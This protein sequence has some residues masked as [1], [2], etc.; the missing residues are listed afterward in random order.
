[1]RALSTFQTILFTT[2]RREILFINNLVQFFLDFFTER[3]L[4][5]AKVKALAIIAGAVLAISVTML[6]SLAVFSRARTPM[7]G[8]LG[9]PAFGFFLLMTAFFYGMD[10]VENGLKKGGET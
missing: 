9:L 6:F 8:S 7:G 4:E 5:K 2:R 3:A 1:L 10:Y